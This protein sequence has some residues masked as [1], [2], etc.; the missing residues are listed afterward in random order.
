MLTGFYAGISGILYNEQKL[1]AISNNTANINTPGFRRTLVMMRSRE[2]PSERSDVHHAV[3]KR[4]PKAFGIQRAGAFKDYSKTG[5]LQATGSDFDIAIPSEL[6][7]AFFAVRHPSA[8]QGKTYYTRNGTLSLGPAD[9][10]NPNS[11][12]V[13]YLAGNILLDANNQPISIDASQGPMV[14]D[15]DGNIK[16]NDITIGEIPLYR[17][18]KSADASIQID[19]NLQAL[20]QKGDSLFEIPEKFKQEFHPLRLTTGQKGIQRLVVQGMR[21]G[22]NVNIFQQLAE[23]MSTTKAS[24]ANTTA[25]K[26]QVE[27]LSK[28]FQIVRS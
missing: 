20:L 28:L 8:P 1:S 10:S 19:S 11:P 25:L 12:T 16:Q 7:N 23:M 13:L 27:G 5:K 17:L 6:K 24:T 22:S 9:P 4:T 3:A 21:E 2:E 18:N 14:I 15:I 26:H